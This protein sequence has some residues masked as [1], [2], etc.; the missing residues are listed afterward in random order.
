MKLG[1][2][3]LTMLFLLVTPIMAVE[4][5]CNMADVS[6]MF[7][8]S[9]KE[10]TESLKSD[11]HSIK[12]SARAEVRSMMNELLDKFLYFIIAVVASI[13]FGGTLF[14]IIK[15]KINKKNKQI[16]DIKSG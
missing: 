13:I 16:E 11:I 12:D 9:I 3:C 6:R 15:N 1:L 5:G 14:Q 8:E 10:N 7:D 2:M 4:I